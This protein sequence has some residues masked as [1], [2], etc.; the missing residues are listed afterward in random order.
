MTPYN[1]PYRISGPKE[2][3]GLKK[4]GFELQGTGGGCYSYFKDIG[5]SGKIIQITDLYGCN[6]P[7]WMTRG[8]ILVG[9]EDHSSEEPYIAASIFPSPKAFL[10]EIRKGGWHKWSPSSVAKTLMKGTGM[11]VG[12]KKEMDALKGNKPYPKDCQFD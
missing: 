1:G 8:R 5:A 9:M 6:P 10:D 2:I 3:N 12:D 11:S 7:R 4:E